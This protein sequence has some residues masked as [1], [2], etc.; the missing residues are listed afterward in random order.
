MQPQ[1][2]AAQIKTTVRS[3]IGV[4]DSVNELRNNNTVAHSNG[5]LIQKR[6]AQLVIRLVNTVE[7]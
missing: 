5:E 7:N 6:E 3:A 1:K 4:V 2:L